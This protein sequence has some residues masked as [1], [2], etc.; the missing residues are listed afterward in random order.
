MSDLSEL[1]KLLDRLD[2]A[3]IQYTLASVSE[4]AIVVGVDVPGEHWKMEFMDDGDIEVEIFKGDGQVFDYG[5]I[6]DLF[7]MAEEDDDDD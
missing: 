5:I 2:E 4:G 3:E 7:E 6:E 1:T